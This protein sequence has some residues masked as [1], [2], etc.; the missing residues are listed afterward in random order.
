MSDLTCFKAYDV[1][2]EIGV[3]IENARVDGVQTNRLFQMVDRASGVIG[4]GF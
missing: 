3:N 4:M 1:R 2:G